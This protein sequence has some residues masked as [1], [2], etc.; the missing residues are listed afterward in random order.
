MKY[1]CIARMATELR[2]GFLPSVFL[3]NAYSNT[4]QA[5]ELGK[6]RSAVTE[7]S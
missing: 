7:Q 6:A 3:D 2:M 5:C 1:E 4:E